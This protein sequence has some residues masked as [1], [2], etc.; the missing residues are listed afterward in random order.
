MK[1]LYGIFLGLSTLVVNF[2]QALE[3][4]TTV[5]TPYQVAAL[6]KAY[7]AYGDDFINYLPA[8]V[9]QCRQGLIEEQRLA[10]AT[11]DSFSYKNVFLSKYGLLKTGMLMASL[12][13]MWAVG[14]KLN[15]NTLAYDVAND[16]ANTIFRDFVSDGS[17][18]FTPVG[19]PRL[20]PNVEYMVE[21]IAFK[22]GYKVRHVNELPINAWR[23]AVAELPEN[24]GRNYQLV[25]NAPVE[26]IEQLQKYQLGAQALAAGAA[27]SGFGLYKDIQVMRAKRAD[28]TAE[29]EKINRMLAVLEKAQ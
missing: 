7:E 6:Y 4:P 3:V 13:G 23:E 1:R 2:T 9:E 22:K 5:L 25:E 14:N 12:V 15:M 8:S 17:S 19:R 29:L 21:D 18:F 10:Q 24:S 26:R 11:I 20:H 27:I 16:F 28:L